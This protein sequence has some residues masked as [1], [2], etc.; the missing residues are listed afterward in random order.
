MTSFNFAPDDR[1][2][3]LAPHPDDETLACAGL[4]QQAL[5][6]GAALRVV[7]LTRGEAN[8][9]PQRAA[10]RRWHIG[11][12]IRSAWGERR[13]YEAFAALNMLGLSR[14][15]AVFLD[16]ADQGLTSAL[17]EGGL[18]AQLAAINAEW[19]PTMLVSPALSDRHPDHNSAALAAML[20]LGPDPGA[21]RHVAYFVHGERS[22]G[23]QLRLELTPR[24]RETKRRAILAYGSQ[25]LLSR[26]RFLRYA[27]TH[28]HYAE[29]SRPH[30]EI[31]EAGSADI[32][33]LPAGRD[34]VQVRTRRRLLLGAMVCVLLDDGRF[35]R[36]TLPPWPN[37][38]VR[39]EGSC[40]AAVRVRRVRAGRSLVLHLPPGAGSALW[41]KVYA[42]GRFLDASGWQRAAVPRD[43]APENSRI[44][45]IIP[46]YNIAHLC[47]PVVREAARHADWVLAVDDGSTDGTRAVLEAV[48]QAEP[49]VR[50]LAHERNAGKGVALLTGFQYALSHLP[51]GTLI[52]LDG[53]AQHR[54]ADIPRV[55]QA[56]CDAGAAMAIG[57]R[58]AFHT[59]PLR[60]R[61][62]NEITGGVLRL[63]YA[64]CPRDTQSGF[65]AFT[66]EFAAQAAAGMR[67]QRYETELYILLSAL[68]QPRGVATVPIP[69]VYLAGNRS[70]HFKPLQDSL[71]IFRALFASWWQAISDTRR[72]PGAK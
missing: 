42:A 23:T 11:T 26:R 13:R 38:E 53:D 12:A 41:I 55:A 10:Y 16:Y 50:V 35:L 71:R 37:D 33:L 46:C 8:V 72:A 57:T 18:T 4:L 7:F 59:M 24:E 29:M 17:L 28:E 43:T 58:V 63:L 21:V 61:L 27:D 44:A 64:P 66:P 67:G 34:L 22:A 3:V 15:H 5:R 19:K 40:N 69:T 56:L 25:M 30:A 47:G 68:E 52:T 60:S 9:W 20:A 51:F 1:I 65:R 39:V 49:R 31:T 32:E 45:C 48:A 54:P 62:G 14:D 6:A 2:L 70:S 36:I